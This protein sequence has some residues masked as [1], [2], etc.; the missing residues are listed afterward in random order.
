EKQNH[1]LSEFGLSGTSWFALIMIYSTPENAINPCNLSYDMVSS[2]TNITRLSDEL[3]EKGWVERH[4]SGEDRRK[5]VLSLTPKGKEL[6]E[7]VLPIQWKHY[8]E[9][10]SGFD[11]GELEQFER[12]LRKLLGRIDEGGTCEE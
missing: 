8:R 7:T 6:V 5:I 12:L 1:Q 2:R 9:L 10:W 3:V 11:A 4:A